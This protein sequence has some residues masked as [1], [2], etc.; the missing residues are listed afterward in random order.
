[1]ISEPHPNVRQVLERLVVALGHEAMAVLERPTP[2]RL[3]SADVLLVESAG[4]GASLAR[5]ARVANPAV[6][7]LCAGV[8]IPSFELKQLEPNLVGFITKPFIPEQLYAA[9]YQALVHGNRLSAASSG[10]GVEG[11]RAA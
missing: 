10:G 9:I 3:R 6:A 1:M 11:R 2:A 7:I 5:T 4:S 8:A